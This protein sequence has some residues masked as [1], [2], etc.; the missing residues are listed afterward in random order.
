MQIS[1]AGSPEPK[2][3]SLN[4]MKRIHRKHRED[5]FLWVE[6]GTV[7]PAPF[8]AGFSRREQGNSYLRARLCLGFPPRLHP[9]PATD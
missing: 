4:A 5:E 3:F 8:G 6:D 2:R 7:K 1:V 9:P